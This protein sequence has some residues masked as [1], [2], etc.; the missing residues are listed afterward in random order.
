MKNKIYIFDTTLRD[1]EQTP[2]AKLNTVEKIEIAKQLEI[3][4]VDVIEAGFPISSPQDFDS[5][6][7]ISKVIKNATICGLTRAVEKDIDV[8]AEALKSA[9][10]PRIHT[11]IGASDMHIK[12]KFKSNRDDILERAI[13]AVKYARNY[14]GDVEFYAEDAG[15]ADLDYLSRMVEAVI[16]AGATVVNIPDT[17]GYNM[18]DEWGK[19]IKYLFD[20]V[21]NIDDAIIS[22][23]NHNDLGLATA[24]TLAGIQ[25]GARQ[26]EVTVNGIG[27]RAG[28]CALEEIVMALKT[29]T[30]SGFDTSINTK[31][32][33]KTS[34]M[35]SSMMGI[36]VQVNKAIVGA[37]AFAHSSG[38]HQDGIIKQRETYEIIDPK[39]IGLDES[40]II[41]TA[42]SGRNALKH[43]LQKIGFEVDS[44]EELAKLY[45]QFL[46]IADRKKEVYDADLRLLMSQTEVQKEYRYKLELI[47]VITGNKNIATA[48][49]QIKDRS[50]KR[51][52]GNDSDKVI[53]GVS[54]GEGPV[55]AGF[56]AIDC[57]VKKDIM[58]K[59]YL[60]QAITEGIDAQGKVSVEIEYNKQKYYGYGADADIIVAS[61][62]SYINAI[63]Q[64]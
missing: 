38:I 61:A 60:V 12:H 59:E 26:V 7:E 40:S 29:R 9:V 30:D 43:R 49:V 56:K 31:E 24:T 14:V 55:D 10:R 21:P 50:I 62:K 37:N 22:I 44:K 19:K 27:E 5:V 6:K 58:L 17:T 63:N 33:I 15:R 11:G 16:K 51:Q 48:T 36:P 1:G 64:I 25:N 13:K 46:Q 20:H 18:P 57:V 23:H 54:T 47:Q 42:R 28:N 45:E 52:A 2:G 53:E 32:I 4:G 8:A 41:L 35:V 34:R 3:L 39:D